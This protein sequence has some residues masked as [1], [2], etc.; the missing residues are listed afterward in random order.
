MPV[1]QAAETHAIIVIGTQIERPLALSD[2][3]GHAMI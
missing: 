1:L 3:E 2:H